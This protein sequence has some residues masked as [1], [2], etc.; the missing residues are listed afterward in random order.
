MTRIISLELN[1]KLRREY[2]MRF[3]SVFFI[4]VAI[5]IFVNIFL[6][7]SSYL[8]L[9]LYERA[10][11]LNNSSKQSE[12][13]NKIREQFNTQVNQ[14]HLLSKKIPSDTKVVDIETARKLFGYVNEGVVITAMEIEP[15][16]KN[17]Q[18]TLR[19]TSTTRDALLTFQDTVK[20]DA[21]FKDFSIPIESLT[22]QKDISF[23]VS[24]IYY[25][26]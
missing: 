8:L 25:E 23:N 11:I 19:G 18:I 4:T 15:K 21:L 10:Y 20:Q 1:K 6:V 26:K 5:A 16:E 3:A 9:T 22:K 24:F 17:P 7:S 13:M 14:V 2:R 12:E